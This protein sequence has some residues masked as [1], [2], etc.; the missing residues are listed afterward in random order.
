VKRL[1][2]LVLGALLALPSV[3]QA[4]TVKVY[5]LRGEQLVSAPREANEGVEAA[6]RVLLQGVTTAERKKGY[7]TAIPGSVTLSSVV[8]DDA[9]VTINL[10]NDFAAADQRYLA[11]LAQVVYTATAAGAETVAIRDREFTRDDFRAP[12]DYTAPKT[13]KVTVSAPKATRTIQRRLVALGYLASNALTGKYDYRTQQ[14]VLAFQSWEGLERDGVAGTK[15]QARL[16]DAGRPKPQEDEDGKYVEIY[17]DRGVVLLVEDGKVVRAVHTSTG[18]GQNSTDLGTPAG[19]FEIERKA[20]RGWSIPFK[21]WQPYAVTWNGGYAL[22]G[23]SDIPTAPSSFGG[24]RVPTQ[25]ARNVWGFVDV[26]TP[27]RVI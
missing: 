17:R 9:K 13:P 11:R 10:S 19:E 7:G 18:V 22:Y 21:F 25:E 26:G 3:A 6:V 8:T 5:F 4:E 2:L 27:V 1:L 15:T 12:E 24:A 23:A 16:A 20:Q 14:A